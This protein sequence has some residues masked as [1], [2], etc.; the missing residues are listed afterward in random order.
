MD[1]LSLIAM[2][3]TTFKGIKTLVDHGAELEHVAQ[4]LGAW[5]TYAADI[6][7]AE[8]E[9]ENP[10]IFKK[11]FDG[12][13]VEQQA[14]NA[15]IA[16]RR[17]EEQES[18]IRSMIMMRFGAETYKEM[19]LLRRKIKKQRE[20]AIYRQRRRRRRLVEWSAGIVASLFVAGIIFG[21]V[22]LIR[23]AP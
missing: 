9:A 17:L 10:P 5:Y 1:P 22:T 6:K 7:Q 19:I 23:G 21:M 20:D 15:V 2:A 16:T 12:Q 3:S 4:K 11:L 18:E 8:Q 14:L 13:S